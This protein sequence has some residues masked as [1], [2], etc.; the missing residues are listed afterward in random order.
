MPD[1]LLETHGSYGSA[2]QSLKLGMGESL[3]QLR[4]QIIRI[5]CDLSAFLLSMVM[6]DTMSFFVSTM[7]KF[8]NAAVLQ[9]P[10]TA[11]NSYNILEESCTPFATSTSLQLH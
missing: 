1:L 7:P 3:L 6:C 5:F 4:C 2:L 8:V 11:L 9:L 10:I